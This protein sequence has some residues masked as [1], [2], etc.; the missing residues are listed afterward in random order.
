MKHFVLTGLTVAALAA[1]ATELK[2]ECAKPGGWEICTAC[3]S[4]ADGVEIHR[5]SLASPTNAVPPKFK[6]SFGVPGGGFAYRWTATTFRAALPPEWW[7]EHESDLAH[8]HPYVAY[9]GQDDANRLAFA[10]SET[11]R[12]VKVR[13]GVHEAD[14]SIT[15][16]LEYFTVPEAPRNG[17][18]TFLR[19]DRRTKPYHEV[20]AEAMAWLE[21]FPENR[22][23]VAPEAAFD[24]LYSSW[25]AFH[26]DV[27][28]RKIAAELRE[29]AKDGMKVVILD[30]GWQALGDLGYG[31]SGDWEVD[32]A[33]FPDMKRHVDEAHALGL[34]YMV[35]LSAPFCGHA[36]K[37]FKRFKGKFLCESSHWKDVAIFDPR[38]PEVREYLVGA[39]VRMVRDYGLDGLKIDFI[40]CFGT[41]GK[42]DPAPAENYAGRDLK[43]VPEAIDRLL[44]ETKAKLDEIRPGAL[45]EFR[46]AY[47]GPAIRK[48]GNMLRASDC[49]ADAIEN[50]RRTVALRILSGRTAVHAD[51]L[52]WSPNDTPEEAARQILAVL[53]ST[54]QY[55]MRL[56][57]L[58][59]EY[60]E[61]M[62][63]WIGFTQRHREALL[64][65]RLVPHRP[66]EGFPL[67]EG[68]SADDRV[69]AA[70]Q[71]GLVVSVADGKSTTVVNASGARGLVVRLAAPPK[72]VRIFDTFGKEVSAEVKAGV[73]LVELP[74]PDSG[75][76]ELSFR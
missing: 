33:K 68:E 37:A 56:N 48:Y 34:K 50:R 67:V 22:P 7:G 52:A 2:V 49:P 51:M 24:P 44:V 6:I 3:V 1:G 58:A 71:P 10:Y 13:S 63:H 65:G 61:M 17:Y 74:V 64:K 35:W 59:P 31:G 70:Y 43:T 38:F 72:A 55:S 29:A 75:Y 14:A 18:E 53:F 4:A 20:A 40:D 41:Y 66:A 21:T 62:R 26:H 19:I 12:N 15:A 5:I 11:L 45:V 76:A 54:I 36:T 28:E 39:F 32:T 9:V 57:D 42:G 73:G 46:Q 60:R 30:D 69:I 27:S 47:V 8:N 25:Y 16:E 23:C